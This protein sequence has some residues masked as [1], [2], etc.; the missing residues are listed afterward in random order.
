MPRRI[1]IGPALAALGALLLLVSLFLD[2]FG[3]RTGWGAFELL[4]LVLAAL[5]VVA[6]VTAGAALAGGGAGD[7]WGDTRWLPGLGLVAV[8][9]V[10]AQLLEPPPAVDGDP[11]TGAWLALAGAVLLLLGGVL[12]AASISISVQVREGRARRRRVSAVDRRA[13]GAVAAPG[14]A[15]EEDDDEPTVAT[16]GRVPF[17]DRRPGAAPPAPAPDEDDFERTQPLSTEERPDR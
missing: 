5:A 1:E 13:P 8:V 12:E 9:A 16:A 14:P 15:S 17:V 3:A 6:L 11:D 4:D 2:W 10:A 7:G